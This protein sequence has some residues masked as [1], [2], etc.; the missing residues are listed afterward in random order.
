[1][2]IIILE[3]VSERHSAWTALG[4]RGVFRGSEK[5][6][7]TRPLAGKTRIMRRRGEAARE[8]LPRQRVFGNKFTFSP[9]YFHFN[10]VFVNH[11]ARGIHFVPDHNSTT[12]ML[13]QHV[14]LFLL[15]K[16]NILTASFFRFT[17]SA[18][19]SG[20]PSATERMLRV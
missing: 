5:A 18:R 10:S 9:F 14:L 2:F 4:V 7:L 12:S 1:M 17:C 19:L 6:T 8:K 11:L 13:P 16:V 20:E 3:Q 15:W